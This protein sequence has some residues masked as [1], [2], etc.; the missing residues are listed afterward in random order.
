MLLRKKLI[1][2]SVA[3]RQH[4]KKYEAREFTCHFR[5]CNQRDPVAPSLVSRREC[6]SGL[7]V[8]LPWCI[9]V[10]LPF[11]GGAPAAPTPVGQGGLFGT[12]SSGMLHLYNPNDDAPGL[13]MSAAF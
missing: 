4:Q 1:H 13:K 8:E 6:P 7:S 11:S 2:V 12:G 3:G 9:C 5:W 10:D